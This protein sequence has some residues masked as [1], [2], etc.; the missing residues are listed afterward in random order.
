MPRAIP[1]RR[2]SGR[3]GHAGAEGGPSPGAAAGGHP[4]ASVDRA[5]GGVVCHEGSVLVVH[6]PRYNDWS[7]PKGHLDPGETWEQAALREVYE[8]TGV[9][10]KITSPPY[11][12]TYLLADDLPKLVLFFAM[13][14]AELPDRLAGD[15]AEVDEA[16][17]WPVA[18]AV[19]ALSYQAER[20][21]CA[22]LAAHDCR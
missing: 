13:T 8:E 17:W 20:A 6:R 2:P 22:A 4:S 18:H 21:A 19:E 14:P 12:V 1:Q 16:A 5:A 7:L 3:V 15:P 11:P 9:R 10:C